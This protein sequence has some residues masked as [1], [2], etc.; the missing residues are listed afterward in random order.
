MS[1]ILRAFQTTAERTAFRF[2]RN[3][4]GRLVT[5]AQT[6][7]TYLVIGEGLG[8]SVCFPLDPSSSG[9]VTDHGALTGLGDDDHTQYTRVDGTR[10]MKLDDCAAPDDNT[11]LDVSTT[12]HG[13]VPKAP[14]DTT[15]FLRGD[16]AWAVPGG[17]G[18]VNVWL[19]D[20]PPSSPSAYDD[21]FTAGSLGGIWSTWDPSSSHTITV[22]TT[23]RMLKIVQTGNAGTRWGGIYQAVPA[24]EF[25]IIAKVS[26]LNQN[27]AS[28]YAM[29][30]FVSENISSSPTTADF[31][32]CDLANNDTAS[33]IFTRTWSAYNGSSSAST[34]RQYLANYLRI[35]CNGTS[36]K[37]DYSLDG[38]GWVQFASVTLGFTPTHMGIALNAS[39][40]TLEATGYCDFFRVAS[41]AGTSAY[42]GFAIGRYV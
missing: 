19:P 26:L 16:A 33:N 31:R 41:G 40:N 25:A 35:R 24:S 10:S 34:N 13:L 6:G 21:E 20:A 2:D 32:T 36:C 23:R 4:I 18:G 11:D 14:N 9:G 1:A 42:N 17:V 27:G 22:D 28:G 39:D 30:V 29:G 5:D 15:K 38:I 8:S 3:A 7:I 37:S 12:K